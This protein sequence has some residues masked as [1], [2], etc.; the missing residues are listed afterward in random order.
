MKIGIFG[1]TFDPIHIGHIISVMEVKLKFG[2]DKVIFI[3][4]RQSPHKETVPS[5]DDDRVTMVEKAI[6]GYGDFHMDSVELDRKGVSYTYDT[7]V[8]LKEKYPGDELFFLMGTDQYQSFE[9][10]YRYED[11]LEMMKFIV[12]MR[13]SDDM[14]IASPFIRADQLVVEVSSTLIR[15]RI[16]EGLPFRHF[17]HASVYEYIKENALYE[18]Q[19]ST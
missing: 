11:L 7:A 16:G 2:L 1:G 4:A 5:A 9:K 12:M 8:Y 14:E 10:W 19:S 6:A 17:L 18:T 15:R 3:P 13:H